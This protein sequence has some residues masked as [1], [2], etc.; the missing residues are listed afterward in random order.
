MIF[1][2]TTTDETVTI[3]F[4]APPTVDLYIEIS[5]VVAKIAPGWIE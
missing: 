2:I 1:W 5:N 3:T 4:N